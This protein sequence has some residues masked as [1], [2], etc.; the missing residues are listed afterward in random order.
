M[1][2]HFF[3]FRPRL[4]S[5]IFLLTVSALAQGETAPV[6]PVDFETVVSTVVAQNPE[7][8]FYEAEIEIARA[9]LRA[10]GSRENPELSVE[11]GRKRVTD[12]AG[13]FEA[14]G[15]AWAVSLSQTFDWPGR[16][17]LRKSIANR[18]V[19][20]AELGLARFKAALC[21][22]ARTLSFGLHATQEKSAAAAEVVARYRE[23]REV[24]LA[25]DP[26]GITPLLETRV[27]EAQELVL[28]RH[29]IEAKLEYK[30]ALVELNQLRGAPVDEPIAIKGANIVFSAPPDLE[31]LLAAARENNFEFRS[32]RLELE[33]QGAGVS[34]ARHERRPSF[35]VGP[36]F[37]QEKAGEKE[38][39]F[40]IGVSMP[41]SVTGRA[42]ANVASAEARRRQ[43]EAA[44]I[45]AERA[46]TREI[47]ASYEALSAKLAA[48]TQWREDSAAKFREAAALADRHYRLGAVPLGTYVE[49]QS[50]YL[51]AVE[52]FLDIRRE[53]LEAA[54]QLQLLTG[55]SSA[56]VTAA[57][58]AE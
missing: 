31:A 52:A 50:S 35:T 16:L 40:G 43:A 12:P 18:D 38:Q 36:Y 13:N 26:A 22:R 30:A 44:L 32:A 55:W 39:T 33:Q 1:I 14:E 25:R 47:I 49:L 57:V 2:P 51:E 46:M 19:A 29:A 5:G 4:S 42:R 37:S 8:A 54:Q 6:S 53:A 41:L 48:G 21:A 7:I 15:T 17:A 45:V 23:L 27:I 9:E 56:L 28:Q 3:S 58:P 20:L 10:A 11:V 34:L 24:F